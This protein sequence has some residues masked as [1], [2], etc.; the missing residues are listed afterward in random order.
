MIDVKT[1]AVPKRNGNGGNVIIKGGSG[2]GKSF[3]PHYLWGQYFDDTE[4]ISGDLKNVDKIEA[5]GKIRTLGSIEAPTG[6]IETVNSSLVDTTTI[7]ADN[8]TITNLGSDNIT[9]QVVSTN[10]LTAV[11][12]EIEDLESNN[13]KAGTI[14]STVGD[15][16]NIYSKA[17]DTHSIRAVEGFIKNILSENI[18]TDYLTVTKA[19]HFFKLIID[20]IKS[21][22]GNIIVT[23]ANMDVD[24]VVQLPNGDYR[25]Y[26]RST[27]DGTEIINTWEIGDQAVCQTFNVHEGVN[28]NVDNKYYWRL[29]TNTGSIRSVH[30]DESNI[31]SATITAFDTNSDGEVTFD[32]IRQVASI[33]GVYNKNTVKGKFNELKYFT[34]IDNISESCFANAKLTEA[35]TPTSI[36]V[37]NRYA[38]RYMTTLQEVKL[39]EG[40]T[41]IR[42]AAFRQCTGLTTLTL[43]S[44]LRQIDYY[45]LSRLT[46]CRYIRIKATT[47]PAIGQGVF[48]E[49]P[50]ILYVPASV[51]DIYKASWGDYADRIEADPYDDETID[52]TELED[53]RIYVDLSDTDKDT[54]SNAAP[55]TGDKISQLGSRSD[56]TRQ[57]AI[58]ISAYDA[59]WLDKG[60]YEKDGKTITKSTLKAPYIA[61]YSGI[62]TFNLTPFRWT[63]LS[64]D[65]N[66]LRG[67]LAL[68]DGTSVEDAISNYSTTYVHIAYANSA[69]GS[70]DFSKTNTT[71]NYSYIG[72]CS[73]FNEID[74]GLTYRD[75]KWS[76][77][78]GNNGQN[79]IQYKL[80]DNNSYAKIDV[81][82]DANEHVIFDSDGYPVRQLKAHL[83]LSVLKVDGYNASVY[84]DNTTML[85]DDI[86]CYYRYD[87]TGNWYIANYNGST[88]GDK[89]YVTDNGRFVLNET[90][91]TY[92]HTVLNVVLT[93]STIGSTNVEILDELVIPI[94][95]EQKATF[96]VIQGKDAAI[97]AT[98]SGYATS[99]DLQTVSNKYT[100][101]NATVDGIQS[102]VENHTSYIG[103]ITS[104]V[105]SLQQTTNGISSRVSTL[106]NSDFVTLSQLTQTSNSIKSEVKAYTDN[107]ISNIDRKY[108]CMTTIDATSLDQDKAYPVLINF[109]SYNGSERIDVRVSRTLNKN[110]GVP[111]FDDNQYI[112]ENEQELNPN[113]NPY[114][115]CSHESGLSV[116][117]QWS[118]IASGW[119]T[120][121]NDNIENW[122]EGDEYRIIDAYSIRWNDGYKPNYVVGSIGQIHQPSIEFIYV[123]GG[124]KYD[125]YSSHKGT[126]IEL[127]PNGYSWSYN[128]EVRRTLN[129]ITNLDDLVVP[130]QDAMTKSEIVQTAENIQFNVYNELKEKTGIDMVSGQITLDADNTI[131][132]GSL[133][134]NNAEDGVIIYN[135][136]GE[137]AVEIVKEPIGT[138]GTSQ[139]AT[140][141][142]KVSAGT[143][144]YIIGDN[145]SYRQF[146]NNYDT[147]AGYLSENKYS[148]QHERI[149]ARIGGGTLNPHCS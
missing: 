68:N 26:A 88:S 70:Q 91:D 55:A 93:M 43:P 122:H 135:D 131:I 130:I 20:E 25:C 32:E 38:F 21:V 51:V 56:T 147:T 148:W 62:N 67:D 61:Q 17:I 79:A 76:K 105:S 40:I 95:A 124:S 73:N 24:N 127:K 104:N 87:N 86:S 71:N 145:N 141:T 9:A 125:V 112:D 63:I 37:I 107:S 28:S 8:G 113:Y 108:V 66:I 5:K 34:G 45:A 42:D 138:F 114:G 23:P 48:D 4:D 149:G 31:K 146:L 77:Y 139:N 133:K 85:Q 58:I 111:K 1:I 30:F 49:T 18:T 102:T 84:D 83:D 82:Y 123:R 15:I 120:N 129:V 103:Q 64:K 3:E 89:F 101:L 54:Y 29:V 100:T 14:T 27:D 74:A 116:N 57:S 36:T 134:I 7:E 106:E 78:K 44:T 136:S 75:Y 39:N 119:G 11:E 110:Y 13:I 2:S 72:F 128:G 115:F 47:P 121:T 33:S 53:A 117:L 109:N 126:N 41:R 16:D 132:N 12:G 97:R 60:Y 46:N 144:T 52:Y 118:T 65:F 59:Q 98:L 35:T 99:S 143:Y 69:D 137:K 22:G 81:T 6:N 140:T 94:V 90:L 19:A 96:D 80:L 92:N 10:T 142:Q 50:A